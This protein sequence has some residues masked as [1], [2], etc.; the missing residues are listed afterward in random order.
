MIYGLRSCHLRFVGFVLGG[1]WLVIS[2]LISRVTI[3]TTH[4]KGL[5]TSLVT[6]HKPPSRAFRTCRVFFWV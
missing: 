1:S 3:V 2:G 6:T 4:T 5:I